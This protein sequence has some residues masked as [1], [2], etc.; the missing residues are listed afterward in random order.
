MRDI[1]KAVTKR[2]VL[3][4]CPPLQRL[5]A[6]RDRLVIERDVAR[7]ECVRL[8]AESFSMKVLVTA[9]EEAASKNAKLR[10]MI[11]RGRQ[12][13]AIIDPDIYDDFPFR[14]GDV[15]KILS[16]DQSATLVVTPDGNSN[17]R[18]EDGKTI[19]MPS[20]F[21]LFEYKGFRLPVH[22]VTL[23]GA[24]PDT[25]EVFGQEHIKNYIRFMDLKAGMTFLEIGCGI[26]RDAL[27]LID[28]IGDKGH[29]VGVDVTRDSI[30]WC[31]KNISSCHPNFAFHHFDAKHELYNP[32]G[33]K[34]SLDFKLPVENR[35][36]D[37]IALGSVF[38]HLFEEE[39]VHYMTEIERVLKF[40]GLA[41]ATF[42]LYSEETISSARRTDLTPFKLTFQHAYG[43]GCYIN[44]LSYPTG[45]VAYTEPAMQRMIKRSGLALHCQILKGVWS[46]AFKDAADGQEVAILRPR[47]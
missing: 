41:Y 26:G 7:A 22:L 8:T 13:A 27:Q 34:T 16:S 42:F 35:S 39:I 17:I 21:D 12:V 29:Y 23:T 43:N 44:D 2:L 20:R 4:V 15:V 33:T 38:T 19:R 9:G 40:G 37:R 25:W 10:L 18:L 3:A 1:I 11:I 46:G 36:I 32:L 45:A 28:L 24:G 14:T 30:L 6:D 5:K 31:Q 47:E